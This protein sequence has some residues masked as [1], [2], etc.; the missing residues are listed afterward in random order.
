[1]GPLANFIDESKKFNNTIVKEF[2]VDGQWNMEMIQHGI[3]DQTMWKVKYIWKILIVVRG[4]LPTNEKFTRFGNDPV[5]CLCGD[6]RLLS[7][8]MRLIRCCFRPLQSLFVETYG[9][10]RCER[11]YGGKQSNITRILYVV[12][13]DN[14]KLMSIVYPHIT[15]SANWKDLIQLA[16]KCVH[17]TKVTIVYWRKPLDQW[18]KLNT[19]GSALSNLG[20]IGA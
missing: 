2:W 20:K 8:K 15:W 5:A 10:N 13:K 3:P 1:M 9:K 7:T 11:K 14:Y 6:G 4:K 12:Y 16:E 19:D 18:V 17:E